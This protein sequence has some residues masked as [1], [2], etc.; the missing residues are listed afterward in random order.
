MSKTSSFKLNDHN[1]I[2]RAFSI[3]DILIQNNIRYSRIFYRSYRSLSCSRS[4]LIRSFYLVRD[5]V[6]FCKNE[7][8]YGNEELLKHIDTL[9]MIL[10]TSYLD[11]EPSLIPNNQSDNI[12][13][14]SKYELR[15]AL[16]IKQ[17]TELGLIDWRSKEHWLFFANH[18][19][20]DDVLGQFCL[21]KSKQPD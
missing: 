16:G 1:S 12:H 21:E 19:G 15:S 9:H 18:Y 2:S 7:P 4:D 6:Y 14:G 20:T 17:V 8:I 10:N 5:Y 3:I 13:F 11:V